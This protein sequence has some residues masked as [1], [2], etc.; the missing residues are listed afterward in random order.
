MLVCFIFC[1]VKLDYLVKL[2]FIR[3]FYRKGIFFF[4]VI[5][6]ESVGRCL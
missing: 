6:K 1:D 3:C 2:V 5:N 4:F